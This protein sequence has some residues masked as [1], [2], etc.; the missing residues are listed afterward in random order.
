MRSM[1][2][3]GITVWRNINGQGRQASCVR[4]LMAGQ[5]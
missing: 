2:L 1:E 3:H 5:L 4:K